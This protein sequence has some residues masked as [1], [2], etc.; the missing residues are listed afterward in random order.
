MVTAAEEV[1][2]L[3]I[4]DYEKAGRISWR[5]GADR[6]GAPGFWTKQLKERNCNLPNWKNW[7]W[8]LKR[9]YSSRRWGRNSKKTL[10]T[11]QWGVK[12][13]EYGVSKAKWRKCFREKLC[14]TLL[15]KSDEVC[16][17]TNGFSN[18]ETVAGLDES[19]SG[20]VRAR[21]T[22]I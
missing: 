14:Q 20:E 10:G 2:S 12:S 21:K 7:V 22:L 18:V 3:W 16:K 15:T 8:A 13:E 11:H 1:V 5:L 4:C 17:L 6:G 9:L 19:I